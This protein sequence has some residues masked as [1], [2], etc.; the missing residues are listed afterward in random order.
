MTKTLLPLIAIL[1]LSSALS[2]AH[3][4]GMTDAQKKELNTQIEAFIKE[5]PK[6]ILDSVM[7][8]QEDMAKAE[9]E[10]M[11]AGVKNLIPA[12]KDYPY[13]PYTGNAKGDVTVV[14]FFDYN[15]GYCKRGYE[16]VQK[17]IDSDKNVKMVFVDLPILGP[18]S[19]EISK[20]ALAAN[21]QGPDK[22][23][24]YHQKLMTYQG[25]K[26]DATLEKLASEAGIDVKKLKKDLADPSIEEQIN[27]NHDLAATVSIQGT[28]AF[29]VQDQI[30]RGYL[31]FDDMEKLID[32]V[33]HPEK[34]DEKKEEPK[35]AK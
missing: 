13:L 2:P 10:K 9:E 30:I 26:D 4:E 6:V 25:N 21:K 15:C 20:W 27:K 16:T 3:A 28:P 11:N 24:K 34:K 14:E 29:V 18:Q 19:H 33:R 23:F 17:L 12:L 5:N 31:E 35:A 22:Y 32:Q 7:K 8:Y 1:T